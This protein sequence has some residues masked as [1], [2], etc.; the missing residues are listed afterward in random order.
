[1]CAKFL[2]VVHAAD[3]FREYPIARILCKQTIAGSQQLDG[4]N[5]S[6]DRN[7]LDVAALTRARETNRS[8]T[9]LQHLDAALDRRRIA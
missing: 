4:R 8:A 1:L 2:A 7:L 3:S 6:N 5:K 9:E